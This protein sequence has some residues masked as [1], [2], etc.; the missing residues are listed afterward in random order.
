MPLM[1][2]ERGQA[3]HAAAKP[4]SQCPCKAGVLQ[5]RQRTLYPA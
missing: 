3:A 5:L 4:E 2:H 1:K